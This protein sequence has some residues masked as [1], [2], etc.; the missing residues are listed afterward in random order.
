MALVKCP[1][2]GENRE[3]KF[4]CESCGVEMCTSCGHK[5]NVACIACSKTASVK[6]TNRRY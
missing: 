5:S 4:K 2:C 1:E 6:E 3:M